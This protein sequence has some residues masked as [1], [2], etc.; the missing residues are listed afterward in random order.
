MKYFKLSEFD[1]PDAP[2]SGANMRLGT[3]LKLDDARLIFRKSIIVTSGFRT[4][5]YAEALK[6]RGYQVATKS[7]HLTGYAA[8]I[9]PKDGL[10]A[11]LTKWAEFLD[12]LWSAGFRR[13]GIMG[14]AVHVD[15][16]PGKVSPAI[17]NYNTTNHTVW[18][19]A[20]NWFEKKTK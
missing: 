15:D 13:F 20:Q 1:S 16:D 18:A 5:A 11:D 14:G 6:K 3:V 9:R 4:K 2:G 10:D 7:A 17:W 12:A 8:D 19:M